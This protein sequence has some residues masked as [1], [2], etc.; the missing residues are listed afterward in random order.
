MPT[1]SINN[2]G[3]TRENFGISFP[4][5][6]NVQGGIVDALLYYNTAP[7]CYGPSTSK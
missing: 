3:C 4:L 1:F 5:G 2:V 7:R 6:F